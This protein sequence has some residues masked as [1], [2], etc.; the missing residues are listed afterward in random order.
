MRHYDGVV[1]EKTQPRKTIPSNPSST[2]SQGRA[3]YIDSP[4]SDT[5]SSRQGDTNSR[6]QGDG[7]S[8]TNTD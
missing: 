5:N 6:F 4:V 1:D 8:K 2:R 3:M 7:R